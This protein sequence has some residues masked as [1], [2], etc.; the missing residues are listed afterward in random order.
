MQCCQCPRPALFAA[1]GK[2]GAPLCLNCYATFQQVMS[3]EFLKSAAMLNHAG[4]QMD[5]MVQ[6][7]L[8]AGLASA[9]PLQADIK[10]AAPKVS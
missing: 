4:H 7:C 1:S 3:I 10:F 5:V 2:D 8:G 9:L 6:R